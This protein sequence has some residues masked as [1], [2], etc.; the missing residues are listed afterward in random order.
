M[1]ITELKNIYQVNRLWEGRIES[2]FE[3]E[4]SQVDV[5]T[6]VAPES[7]CVTALVVTNLFEKG[8]AN[9]S[10]RYSYPSGKH[11]DDANNWEK[12]DSHT[13][14]II[15]KGAKFALLERTLDDTKYYVRIDW[16]GNAQ[17]VEAGKHYFTLST[18]D[19]AVAFSC[20]YSP[21]ADIKP[22]QAYKRALSASAAAWRKYWNEGGVVDFSECTDSRAAE[23]ERRVVLSQYIKATNCRGSMPPQESGLTYNTWFG[24][25]HLEMAWWHLL[26]FSL[27]GQKKRP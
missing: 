4:E 1:P 9:L 5:F 24:R 6:L 27:W 7:D 21:T 12:A 14:K 13:T 3:V 17:F 2:R 20:T 8:Q 16:E 18:S 19:N 15:G 22:A 26:D 25:P 11:S 10:F 23:L